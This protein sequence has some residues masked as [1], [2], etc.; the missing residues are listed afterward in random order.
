M[1]W[2]DKAMIADEM[3]AYFERA[4][5]H[6]R[7]AY[8]L[9]DDRFR[10][11]HYS[12]SLLDLFPLV[13]GIEAFKC[14][15]CFERESPC[16][17]CPLRSSGD[18]N[19]VLDRTMV[20]PHGDKGRRFFRVITIPIE[21][22]GAA[23]DGPRL[24]EFI[25]E[26]TYQ[27]QIMSKYSDL[28][29]F[30][31]SI[32]THAPVAIF[33]L[34]RQ[35]RITTTNPAHL[36][37]AGD[38]PREKVLGF[39][40]LHSENV[41]ISGLDT[42]LR[43]GLAGESFDVSDL[44]F[45]GNI[46][47]RRL[48]MSLRGVPLKNDQGEVESLICILED[49]TEKTR[50]LKELKRLKE[51][52]EHIIESMT[53]GV[54][55]VDSEFRFQTV[56]KALTELFDIS[57]EE[58]LKKDFR[59]FFD[60][61]GAKP[62]IRDMVAVSRSGSTMPTKNCL[63]THRG[64]VLSLNYKMM[65]LFNSEEQQ[66]G[67]VILFEDVTEKEKME[68]RFRS[69]FE[70]ANDGIL[71]TD[72]DLRVL[73]VNR[74]AMDLFENRPLEGESLYGLFSGETLARLKSRVSALL[75]GK[76]TQPYEIIFGQGPR[77][78]YLEVNMSLMEE[79]ERLKRI[80][81]IIR[82][83][84]QRV[85]LEEQLMQATKMS[86]LG[87]MAAGFA[88]EIN[89]PIATIAACSEEI[90]DLMSEA[91]HEIA[92]SLKENLDNLHGFIQEQ[93]YR[94]KKINEDLLDFARTKKPVLGETD[95]NQAIIKIVSFHGFTDDASA[96]RVR[97]DLDPGLPS[98]K[99]NASQLQQVFLNLLNNALDATEDGGHVNIIS[100]RKDGHIQIVFEDTGVGMG[101]E[102]MA[103]IFDPLFTT[104][105]PNKGTGLGL[106]I[107]YRIVQRLR[108]TIDASS[109]EGRGSTFTI[110]LPAV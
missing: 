74:R 35:G 31:R 49:T 85:K 83:I 39:D 44:P 9:I 96:G 62:L 37:I 1:H 79:H 94:C 87:E 36:K 7:S 73:S 40:W 90:A 84:S 4:L 6:T 22:N 46:T 13:G 28:Y 10:I 95:I 100:R 65:P 43:K 105:P 56:N 50:Y 107:C 24:F 80:Q 78:L 52:N 53:D 18:E 92:P 98:I 103:K 51:Y 104:K 55:V 102:Q 71:L 93:C 42:Y 108:G 12:D 58:V 5:L 60:R 34:D 15:R 41:Q 81:F 48:Y 23:G 47:G 21:R 110:T 38:A 30:H 64:R 14:F 70:N 16:P 57:P 77:T 99:S 26:I 69:L 66:Y 27:H 106:S 20:I 3:S 97:L 32:L 19:E 101:Q 33:T 59:T 8:A 29:E 86:A 72:K 88:H 76:G 25:Q 2:T 109:S 17:E 11:V 45:T 91:G 82:D 61:T 68:I 54:A 89:N 63:I 67:V 75:R